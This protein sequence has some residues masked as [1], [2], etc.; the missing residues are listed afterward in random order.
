MFINK[1]S[2]LLENEVLKRKI[3]A[4]ED[5]VEAQ[6]ELNETNKKV[7]EQKENQINFLKRLIQERELKQ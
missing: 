4:L 3:K 2:L 6:R 7:I 1:R 5:L